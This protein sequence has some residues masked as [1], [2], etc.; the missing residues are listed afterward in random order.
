MLNNNM[1]EQVKQLTGLSTN[2]ANVFLAQGIIESFVGKTV[3]EVT[4]DKDIEWLTRAIA[5]QTIYITDNK[6][7]TTGEK[8]IRQD[9]STVQFNQN[10]VISPLAAET[11]KNLSWNVS[12]RQ[13]QFAPFVSGVTEC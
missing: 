13:I 12:I 11:C 4:D 2:K 8:T 1:I 7:F 6:V 5:Y 10:Y 3:D 9:D